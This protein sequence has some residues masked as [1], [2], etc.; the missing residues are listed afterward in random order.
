MSKRLAGVPREWRPIAERYIKV[1][2]AAGVEPAKVDQLIQWGLGFKGAEEELL[3]AFE[4]QAKLMRLPAEQADRIATVGMETRE[5][6]NNYG[7]YQPAPDADTKL[8][9]DIRQYRQQ[10]PDA[11]SADDDM[12]A[13]ELRLIDKEL[14]NKPDPIVMPKAE[15][16][17]VAAPIGSRVAEIRRIM[18]DE[19]DRYDRSPDLQ[20]EQLSLIEAQLAASRPTAAIQSSPIETASASTGS[21]GA[22]SSQA[23][24]EGSA[25]E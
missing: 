8:L 16:G 10:W 4:A 5:T 13:I 17:K 6:I 23:T 22:M 2:E 19:P 11:Y 9:A 24:S 15:Q 20:A 21:G 7:L 14:G 18:R 1:W 3:P 25:S 12:K